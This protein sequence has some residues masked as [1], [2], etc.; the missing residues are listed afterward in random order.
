M[1]LYADYISER[2]N[3]KIIES[4]SGFATYRYLDERTVYI[5]DIYT[6]PEMRKK[7]GASQFANMIADEAREKGCK[8]MLGT[9]QLSAK[10]SATGIKVLLSYG[11]E[12][13]SASN[14]VIIFRKEL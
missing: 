6:V 2:T 13:K 3:D 5:V 8:E 4:P 14:D 12:P 11:F 9:V 10:G 7:G 1:S